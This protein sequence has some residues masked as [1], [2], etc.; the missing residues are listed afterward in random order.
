MNLKRNYAAGLRTQR[1]IYC[2][3][4]LGK[5][6]EMSMLTCSL[7]FR[8]KITLVKAHVKH[9]CKI[10]E[11]RVKYVRAWVELNSSH[12]YLQIDN[13]YVSQPSHHSCSPASPSLLPILSLSDPKGPTEPTRRRSKLHM[14]HACHASR[15]TPPAY[16]DGIARIWK[17]EFRIRRRLSNKEHRTKRVATR[18]DK[19]PWAPLSSC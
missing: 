7:S 3:A 1:K 15:D 6:A 12:N 5:D 16:F 10:G 17:I 19:D 11:N 2:T 8:D 13:H 4:D 9:T 18:Q 14:A